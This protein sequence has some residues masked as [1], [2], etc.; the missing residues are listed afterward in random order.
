MEIQS[1]PNSVG[2]IIPE[3]KPS[4]KTKLRIMTSQTELFGEI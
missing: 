4:Y 3:L 1:Q 2:S